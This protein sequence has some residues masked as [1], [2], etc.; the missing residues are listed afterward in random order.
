MSGNHS[1][2]RMQ[3]WQR[4]LVFIALVLAVPSAFAQF[5]LLPRPVLTEV[6]KLS[7]ADT[8]RAYRADGARHLY[9]AYP[10]RI[11]KGKLPPLMYAI[12]IIETEID[13][14]GHVVDAVIVRA[15]AAA[16]EVGPWALQMIRNAGPFP[17]PEKLGRVK[18]TDIWLVDKSGNFQLD[19]L[20]EGQR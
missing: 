20:T 8:E 17:R 6:Q 3:P 19:T 14:N 13:E 2:P 18:Y 12:A 16:K 11:Y 15:P 1:M 5:S 7:Q 10:L 4:L 9:S